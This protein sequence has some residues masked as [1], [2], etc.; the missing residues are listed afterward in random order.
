MARNSFKTLTF[1]IFALVV[2]LPAWG[3]N[4]PSGISTGIGIG[5][6]ERPGRAPIGITSASP[7]IDG[8]RVGIETD[9]SSWKTTLWIVNA[10]GGD[11]SPFVVSYFDQNGNPFHVSLTM[12]S[13]AFFPTSFQV[14]GGLCSNAALRFILGGWQGTAAAQSFSIQL[15]ANGGIIISAIVEHVDSNGALL[16]PPTALR[17]RGTRAS[18]SGNKFAVALDVEQGIETTLTLNNHTLYPVNVTFAAYGPDGVNTPGRT[19]FAT[20][21]MVIPPGMTTKTA[22]DVFLNSPDFAQFLASMGN[23]INQGFLS[24]TTD[25]PV[26]LG[27][28][29]EIIDTASGDFDQVVWQAFPGV[30]PSGH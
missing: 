30:A 8:A 24:V 16:E 27:V 12:A 20:V 18:S 13:G 28:T 19:P 25:Q 9:G 29:Q 23:D 15:Q 4:R 2:L 11:M 6:G 14:Q 22:G 3:Q 21:Q 17:E 10:Y 7:V 26:V 1:A 5:I